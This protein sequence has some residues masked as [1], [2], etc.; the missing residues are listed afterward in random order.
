MR[1]LKSS[2]SIINAIVVKE[3]NLRSVFSAPS[4]LRSPLNQTVSGELLGV[5]IGTSGRGAKFRFQVLMEIKKVSIN[6]GVA[7]Y[8]RLDVPLETSP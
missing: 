3:P 7:S 5:W 4:T 1:R 8:S 6:N 2:R